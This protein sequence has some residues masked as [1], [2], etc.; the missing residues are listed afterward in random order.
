[1]KKII[2]LNM[3]VLLSISGCGEEKSEK[4][5]NPGVVEY[6]TGAQHIKAYD[7]TKSKLD[8]INKTLEERNEAVK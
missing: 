2:V 8:D 3:V 6:M 4:P 7:R 1:M 5:A